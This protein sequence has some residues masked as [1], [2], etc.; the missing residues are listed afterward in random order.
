MITLEEFDLSEQGKPY[1][2]AD[3]SLVL[4][5]LVLLLWPRILIWVPVKYRAKC[6]EKALTEAANRKQSQIGIEL[7]QFTTELSKWSYSE[8]NL[9]V[10]MWCGQLLNWD[11]VLGVA[12]PQ[13]SALGLLLLLIYVND[14][15]SIEIH[16]AGSMLQ[17]HG[18][19]RWWIV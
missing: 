8:N 17:Y 16:A 9:N 11:P 19:Y 7:K 4:T 18:W 14:I 15:L 2:S 3:F 12:T 10:T 6:L 5:A 1:K 13:D